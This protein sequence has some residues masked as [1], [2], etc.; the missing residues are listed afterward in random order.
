MQPY[1]VLQRA[2]QGWSSFL[3]SASQVDNVRW[4]KGIAEQRQGLRKFRRAEIG[5]CY[6]SAFLSWLPE[7]Q[8]FSQVAVGLLPE[9]T[10]DFFSSNQKTKLKKKPKKTQQQRGRLFLVSTTLQDFYAVVSV[11]NQIWYLFALV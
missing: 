6:R 8:C 10:K 11:N 9:Y 5:G 2:D 1:E 7:L 4:E 3:P